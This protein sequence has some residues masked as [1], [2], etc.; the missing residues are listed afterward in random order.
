[1]SDLL[2]ISPIILTA[3]TGLFLMVL[4]LTSGNDGPKGWLGYV[5][6]VGFAIAGLAAWQLWSGAPQLELPYLARV[7]KFDNYGMFFGE[8]IVF[9]GSAA[10]LLYVDYLPE[11]DIDRGEHYALLAFSVTGA[12][13]LVTAVEFV[14]MFLGLEIMSLALYVM[15]AGKPKSALSVEAGIKYFVLGGLASAFFLFGVALYY[16]A[17]GTLELTSA[18]P[19]SLNWANLGDGLPFGAFALLITGLGFKIAAVPFHMWTPDVYEGSPTPVTTFMAGAVKAAA[20]AVM[21]R[22]VLTA[23]ASTGS[24]PLF[25]SV[26]A[27][28]LAMSV[29]TMVVGNLFG[30]VQDNVKRI[31]AYSSISHAGYLLMGMWAMGPGGLLNDGVPFYMM[32]YVVATVGAF[33]V[34]ALLGGKSEEDM[35]LNKIAGIGHRKPLLSVIMLLSVLSLAGI[36]PMAG[37]MGK[38]NL[39]KQILAVDPEGNVVWVIVAVANSLVALYYYL[40]IVVYMYFR[41]PDGE[42]ATPIKSSS[43]MFALVVVALVILFVGILPGRFIKASKIASAGAIVGPRTA[44][45]IR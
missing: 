6:A 12:L 27:L 31:L 42:P 36:P 29:I 3:V 18:M 32:T 21:G 20:F 33:G 1:M 24:G 30:I 14:T 23:F 2:L 16:G 44:E 13:I 5:T 40:R 39:F 43:G 9:A 7:L 17:T 38:F 28:L 25:E 11:Q 45:I 26:G 41:E 15:A 10:A 34:L 35:S 19:K 22:V 37:F 8:L 4:D